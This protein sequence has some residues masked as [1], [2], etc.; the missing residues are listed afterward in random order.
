MPD[1]SG[2]ERTE[3]ATPR[4]R[5]EQRERGQVARSVEVNNVAVLLGGLALL[6]MAAP[7]T[8]RGLAGLMRYAL[9][10]AM[11]RPL[12]AGSAQEI[13]GAI[14]LETLGFC[15]P[16]VVGLLVI[17]GLA[18]YGQV[19]WVIAGE[20]IAPNLSHLDPLAGLKRLVSLRA[21]MRVA[22]ALIKLAIITAVFYLAIR[23]RVMEFFP[24][25]HAHPAG[26][27]DY[28]CRTTALV[29]F[30]A[31]AVLVV[32]ALVD[33]GYQH[34]EHER[35]LRMT[36][37]E[38]RE[39]LKRLE[40]DPLVKSRVRQVQ[41]EMARRRMMHDLPK[42]DA[43]VTNPTHYA[44][45]LRY[46]AAK[47]EAPTV[48]AK[49]CDRLAE[50]IREIAGFHGIPF[51][52]DPYLARALYKSVEVGQAIPYALYQAVA[53]VLTYVYQIRRRRQA[54]Y[55]PL[56]AEPALRPSAAATPTVGA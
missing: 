28:L 39:E 13:L 31:C 5:Q 21:V 36:R 50:K 6:Y 32:I 30:Q 44:V 19:G 20:A 7:L 37:Q 54:R 40:G 22:L 17:A 56:N 51:V 55:M 38:V 45:A 24:L 35:S 18:A 29:G 26:L 43:I 11:A 33:Y 48:V 23:N 52:E 49:G 46:D 34:W 12:T 41:R 25:V 10:P 47:M 27:F 1:E 3:D 8:Y 2:E 16:L 14:T 4:R 53:R 15:A 42:A 9:G